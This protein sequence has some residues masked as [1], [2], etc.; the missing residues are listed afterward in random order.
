MD[1][2]HLIILN[3][4]LM[5]K[6]K[7]VFPY[8]SPIIIFDIKSDVCKANNGK[9]EKRTRNISRRMHFVING[10]KCNLPKI[11]WCEGGMQLSGIETK[12]VLED[13]LN[14]ISGY[15]MVRHDN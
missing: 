12:N 3:K 7:Y 2:S 13:E 4:Y 1:L 15:T 14:P 8:Q 9:D 10:E 11:V 6:D 5:K